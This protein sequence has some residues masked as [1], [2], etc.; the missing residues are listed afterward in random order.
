MMLPGCGKDDSP[1]GPSD[2]DPIA[3]FTESGGTVTPATIAFTNTSLHADAYVWRFGD[4]DTTTIANPT[5]TY[6]AHGDY[7]V[8]L[9]AKNTAT[10]RIDIESK[11]I[12]ITPGRVFLETITVE[13]IPFT[14]P[15]GA[16]WDLT[17]GPDLYPDLYDES[18]GVLFTS[19][20]YYLDVSPS[21]LPLQ[22]ELNPGLRLTDWAAAYFVRLWDYDDLSGDDY[23]G[24]AN[25]FR[26]NDVIASSG[27][28]ST[29]TRSNNSGTIRVYI[30]LRWQ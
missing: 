7:I 12:A 6:S 10:G 4:G 29:V 14:D 18:V 3:S 9:E 20:Y 25:G 11:L 15:Y 2:A 30:S 27:Y 22:Y 5:H 16:G 19:S 17:S 8:V 28:V 24:S 26:I 13:A 23:I 1:A 21:D